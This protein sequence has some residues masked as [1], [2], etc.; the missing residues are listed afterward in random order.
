MVPRPLP[1]AQSFA[2]Q[3]TDPRETGNIGRLHLLTDGKWVWWS[4]LA[5]CV[6]RHHV[7][8]D[9]V[10][11]AHARGNHWAVPQLGDEELEAMLTLLLEDEGEL[12]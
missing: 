11:V 7:E 9:P 3:L 6:R 10:L 12:D 8:L 1:R 4:D 5:H 2:R